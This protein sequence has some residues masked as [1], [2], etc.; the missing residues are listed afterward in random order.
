[1]FDS[2]LILQFAFSPK[3]TLK[4]NS[5]LVGIGA[6]ISCVIFCL[7]PRVSK[8]FKEIDILI[9]GGFFLAVIG[10]LVYIPY[11]LDP[12]KLGISREYFV[13]DTLHHLEDDD[14]RVL[15]E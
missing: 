3:E 8:V 12:P 1:M 13:N 5:I 4:Y 9:W 10:K 7:L 15:G 6:F 11:R 14:P 2:L